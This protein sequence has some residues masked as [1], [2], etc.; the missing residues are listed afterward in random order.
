MGGGG[1]FLRVTCVHGP[2]CM[3]QQAPLVSG[4]YVVLPVVRERCLVMRFVTEGSTLPVSSVVIINLY[5]WARVSVCV[6]ALLTLSLRSYLLVSA[7]R[8]PLDR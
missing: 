2:A 5:P 7:S 8:S 6:V 1:P 4:M 3:R